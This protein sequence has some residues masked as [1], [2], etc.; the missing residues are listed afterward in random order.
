M[1]HE[2]DQDIQYKVKLSTWK[3]ILSIVFQSKR[4]IFLLA[5][6][7]GSLAILDTLIH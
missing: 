3:K 4:R 6:F 2:D 7:S 1:H 5:L